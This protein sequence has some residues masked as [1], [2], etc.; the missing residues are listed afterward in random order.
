MSD[1]PQ[2]VL[3][4]EFNAPRALVWKTWTE[5]EYLNRWY[6]PGVETII[7][8]LDVTPGGLWL[9]EMKWGGNSNYQKA[10]YT[11]VEPPTRLVFLQS[12]TDGDWNIIAN[13]MMQDWPRVLETDVSFTEAD[14]KT[15]M[16]LVWTPHEASEAEIACFAGALA[17]LDQGWGKG[18]EML[19][20]LLAELQAT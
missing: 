2:Y 4:R 10:E 3:E 18:M 7:H 19:A 5:A 12:V 11:T 16:R 15:T 6:G 9:N 13:P 8:Q 17:G 20:E 14:G 1:L